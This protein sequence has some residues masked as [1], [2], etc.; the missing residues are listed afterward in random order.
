MVA[1]WP[2]HSELQQAAALRMLCIW[3]LATLVALTIG[4]PASEDH[5]INFVVRNIT[6]LWEEVSDIRQEIVRHLHEGHKEDRHDEVM[7]EVEGLH[8]EH[9]VHHLHHPHK[10]HNEHHSNELLRH[11]EEAHGHIDDHTAGQPVHGHLHGHGVSHDHYHGAPKVRD[12]DDDSHEDDH[13]EERDG[14]E[15]DHDHDHDHDHGHDHDHS[16]SAEHVTH[17]NPDEHDAHGLH[18]H[19]DEHEYGH[20]HGHDHISDDHDHDDHSQ[21]ASQPSRPPG[22]PGMARPGSDTLPGSLRSGRHPSD[23]W[24]HAACA[25]RPNKDMPTSHVNGSVIISQRKDGKGPVYFDIHLRGIDVA[26]TGR[27]HGFHV[28]ERQVTDDS[29]GSTG[30]HF[31]PAG[32]THGAPDSDIRHVGDLGN[33]EVDENGELHGYVIDDDKVAF[34]GAN[35]IIGKAL[36][37]HAGVDDLGQGGDAGS[38]STGNAGGRLACCTIHM[39]PSGRL[40]DFVTFRIKG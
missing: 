32:V 19:E 16:E 37:V 29:C 15:H 21:G 6:A 13:D 18:S 23:T 1:I 30:G 11:L 9:H 10:G 27:I 39:G 24:M 28:H 36:V 8:H 2:G 22:V 3:T 17:A 20:E 25:L 5:D 14:H 34:N 4:A 12:D 26:N 40:E 35:S 33:I 7:R 31:N 38:L